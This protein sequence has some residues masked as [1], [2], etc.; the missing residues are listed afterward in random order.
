MVNLD[1]SDLFL[2]IEEAGLEIDD[3]QPAELAILKSRGY[4]VLEVYVLEEM[5]SGNKKAQRI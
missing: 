1:S 5:D 3:G 4:E 2:E